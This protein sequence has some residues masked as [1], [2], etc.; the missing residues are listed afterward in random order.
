MRALRSQGASLRELADKFGMTPGG[1]W[2]ITDRPPPPSTARERDRQAFEARMVALDALRLRRG[3]MKIDRLAGL[4][5]AS[6]QRVRRWL[7][8]HEGDM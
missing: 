3:G 8:E 4:A 1:V 2:A 5:G 6:A 7:A